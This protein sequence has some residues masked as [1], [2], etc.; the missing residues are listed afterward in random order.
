[1]TP[2]FKIKKE[3][4]KEAHKFLQARGSQIQSNSGCSRKCHHGEKNGSQ[5]ISSLLLFFEDFFVLM[6]TIFKACVERVTISLLLLTFLFF[7]PWG[8]WGLSSPSRGQTLTPCLEG[9]VL[10]TGPPGSPN[11]PLLSLKCATLWAGY[12]S[13]PR[14]CVASRS[15]PRSG[16]H[17]RWGGAW[18]PSGRRS[19]ASPGRA[20]AGCAPAPAAPSACALRSWPSALWWPSSELSWHTAFQHRGHLLYAQETPFRKLKMKRKKSEDY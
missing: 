9:K 20:T 8:M 16:T 12:N 5:K 15:E 10:T 2:V 6:W 13:G 17:L 14:V 18:S 3:C 4:E 7:W 11:T 19:A 1:M